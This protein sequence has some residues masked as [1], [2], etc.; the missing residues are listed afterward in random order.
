MSIPL[1]SVY[2]GG[3]IVPIC[4]LTVDIS[5]WLDVNED[6]SIFVGTREQGDTLSSSARRAKSFI[7][8]VTL[9]LGKASKEC[10]LLRSSKSHV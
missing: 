7:K 1:D 4:L 10:L 5:A 9:H 6:S 8:S 3:V 2:K